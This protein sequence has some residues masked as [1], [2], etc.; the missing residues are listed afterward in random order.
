MPVKIYK[1]KLSKDQ[2]NYV[3]KC[4]NSFE[5]GYYFKKAH[6]KNT[7]FTYIDLRSQVEDYKLFKVCMKK[8]R[9]NYFQKEG[10]PVFGLYERSPFRPFTYHAHLVVAQRFEEIGRDQIITKWQ[11]VKKSMGFKDISF[12]VK[13]DKPWDYNPLGKFFYNLKVSKGNTWFKTKP[14]KET[15]E[16]DFNINLGGK[17]PWA[18]KPMPKDHFHAQKLDRMLNRYFYSQSHNPKR[19]KVIYSLFDPVLKNIWNYKN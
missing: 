12:S 15:G 11:N 17:L 10:F 5:R 1:R 19:R 3:Q 18:G 2:R 13:I 4:A 7:S 6:L 9:E 8:M 16:F 14:F